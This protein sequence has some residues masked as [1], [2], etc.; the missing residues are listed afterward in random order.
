MKLGTVVVAGMIL[1]CAV[2]ALTLPEKK[3]DS[4]S[5]DLRELEIYKNKL[6]Y[7]EAIGKYKT[8]IN[9]TEDPRERYALCIEMRDYCK[10]NGEDDSYAYACRMAVQLDPSDTVSADGVLASIESKQD[11]FSY[12]HSL[13]RSDGLTEEAYE[14]YSSY[15]D[16]IKGDHSLKSILAQDIGE[17]CDDSFA[18]A[19]V[20]GQSDAVIGV[21]GEELVGSSHGKID[22]YS[23]GTGYIAAEDNGQKVYVNAK[24]RRKLVPYDYSNDQLVYYD[25]L[26]RFEGGLANF[27]AKDGTWG[28]LN[29]S[30]SERYSGLEG[31][32]PL[33]DGFFAAK[34]GG[35]WNVVYHGSSA[36]VTLFTCD[37]LFLDGDRFISGTLADGTAKTRTCMVYAKNSG[38]PGWKLYSITVDLS[39]KE[40]KGSGAQAGQLSFDDVKLFGER[41]GAVKTAGA[42]GFVG[43]DGELITKMGTYQDARSMSCG[44]CAVMDSSGMWGYIDANGRTTIEPQFEQ[45]NSLS[46]I[47]TA[48]VKTTDGWKLLTLDEYK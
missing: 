45:A 16:S 26:G 2:T 41:V 1:L 25:Y 47:G 11:M 20:G 21:D 10:D 17:W 44:M 30:L 22:S 34:S 36:D 27:R 32:T 33:S 31:A 14:H 28:Y 6:M 15:Y 46:S 42:W 37:E 48:T 7:S 5:V 18:I 3:D 13:M 4:A 43:R 8:I 9:N 24:G 39:E 12:V 35:S 38:D 19:S 29:T 23:P 40:P